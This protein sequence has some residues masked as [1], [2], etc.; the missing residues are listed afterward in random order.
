MMIGIPIIQLVLFGFAIN[1]D[2]H[3]LP[4]LVE[5]NDESPVARAVLS[6]MDTS[7]YF[8][9]IGFVTGAAEGDRALRDGT[10]NFVVVIPPDFER[11]IVRGLSPQILISADASDPTAVGSAIGALSG[12]LETRDRRDARRPARLGRR[13]AGAVLGGRCTGSSTRKGETRSTSCPA[14]SRSSSR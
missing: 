8:D 1:T 4:T 11:D 2:P 6:A 14:C 12:I 7:E 9:F 10:A 5:M 3:N 13:P